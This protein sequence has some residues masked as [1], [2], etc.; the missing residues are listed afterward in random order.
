MP[1]PAGT[2]ATLSPL[3]FAILKTRRALPDA[4]VNIFDLDETTVIIDQ[5][6]YDQ[7]DVLDET[8]NW[9]LFTLAPAP[10]I[11]AAEI[12][13]TVSSAMTLFGVTIVPIAA[14]DRD[15]FLVKKADLAAAITRFETLGIKIIKN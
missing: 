4:F 13:T 6:K 11:T 5:T 12:I 1:I 3:L 2:I 14:F 8:L 10:V 7:A 15:H 9:R